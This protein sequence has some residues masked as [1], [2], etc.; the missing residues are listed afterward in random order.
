MGVLRRE[1]EGCDQTAKTADSQRKFKPPRRQHLPTPARCS[2]E[3]TQQTSATPSEA[4]LQ[5]ARSNA[6]DESWRPGP[7][8]DILGGEP[9]PSVEMAWLL[10]CSDRMDEDAQQV[11]AFLSNHGLDR[12]AALL[13]DEPSGLGSS[14]QALSEADDVLLEKAGLPAS[15]RA[16]LLT[17]L[18]ADSKVIE[19]AV[20]TAVASRPLAVASE[21][22]A[23]VGQASSR[24]SPE[25]TSAPPGSRPPNGE[26]SNLG[27]APPGWACLTPTP[28]ILP[29][30]IVQTSNACTGG[31]ENIGG[32]G[33]D[34]QRPANVNTLLQPHVARPPSSSA[35]AGS[36]SDITAV[37]ASVVAGMTAGGMIP[38]AGSRPGTSQG[39][40]DRVPCH[41]CYKQMSCKFALEVEIE[42]APHH[43][44]NETCVE[45]FRQ[46]LQK[47]LEYQRELNEL[48]SCVQAAAEQAEAE[49]EA[50]TEAQAQ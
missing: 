5:S 43:F 14:L 23:E 41:H 47:R 45:G 49:A 9:A 34:L 30:R 3:A 27:H 42:A 26:W 15:P 33:D 11:V 29:T 32:N 21:L 35:F 18:K 17:A 13:A 44:C 10:S 20:S 22:G 38:E 6:N 40:T 7:G 19:A 2:S 24:P 8:A 1:V 46:G 4:G 28:C 37:P 25:P 39:T 50:Q 36:Q 48:R 31:D 12:Y 16:R